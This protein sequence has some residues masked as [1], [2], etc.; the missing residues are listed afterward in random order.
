M[1]FQNRGGISENLDNLERLSY[2]LRNFAA[3]CDDVS[4]KLPIE[5]PD[6]QVEELV[7]QLKI[8]CRLLI[9]NQ[10]KLG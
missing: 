2:S 10:T 9:K 4:R 3:V 8:H 6:K 7:L 5:L 1:E